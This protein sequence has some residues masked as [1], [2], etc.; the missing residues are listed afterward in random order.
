METLNLAEVAII[1]ILACVI[2]FLLGIYYFQIKNKFKNRGSELEKEN[3]GPKDA[4]SALEEEVN[5]L[6][7]IINQK[8]TLISQFEI[9]EDILKN[10]VS[11]L[12]KEN[13]GLKD[14]KS[15]LEEEVNNLKA[16]IN[17][18]DTLIREFEI[19]EDILKNIFRSEVIKEK[20][21]ERF[22]E[23]ERFLFKE[24]IPQI[25]RM[26]L[27]ENEYEIFEEI[28]AEFE[29]YK[30]LHIK[31][32]QQ[33]YT[34]F[35]FV[36]KFSTGKSSLIN[37]LLEEK[38]LPVDLSP[39]TAVPTF[40]MYGIEK[41]IFFEDFKDSIRK[42]D[43]SYFS[44]IT[45]ERLK[46]VPLSDLIK[47]FIVYTEKEFLKDCIIMDTPGIF[48][49]DGNIE[50]TRKKLHTWISEV[51]NIFWV[52]DITEGCIDRNSLSILSELSNKKIFLII[53]K[54]DAVSPS[55]RKKVVA[56]I[57][58]SCNKKKI[59][60]S[61]IILY[62]SKEDIDGCRENLLNV[63]KINTSKAENDTFYKY[64]RKFFENVIKKTKT[65]YQNVINSGDRNAI[66]EAEKKWKKIENLEKKFKDMILNI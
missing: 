13:L 62:S 8:D 57:K 19:K 16:I 60:I 38:V 26:N 25:D 3:L 21:D 14:A 51:E 29:K 39:S 63:I 56:G 17:Q 20:D 15:A 31:P 41:D 23:I 2:F 11:E 4:K 66:Y 33:K 65:E 34:N 24:M 64:M 5:N 44:K 43:A 52:I 12:E 36:G 55:N 9:K 18:K 54:A 53:N 32:W 48:S 46:H 35:A 50:K 61:D 40:I 10:R 37:S 28:K 47:Y 27:F 49:D 42:L 6:K 58:D 45:E 7:A 22:S 1:L 30:I 59:N